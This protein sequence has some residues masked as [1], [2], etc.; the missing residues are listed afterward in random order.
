MKGFTQK[1]SL[2]WHTDKLQTSLW[3]GWLLT[4]FS[5]FWSDNLV[6]FK[7]L[8]IGYLFPFRIFLPVTA[9]LYLIWA[10]REKDFFWKN[11]SLLEKWVYVLIAVMLMYGVLSLPRALNFM[12]TFQKLFNLC[13]D[14]CF[15]FLMLRLCQNKKLLCYTI[16]VCGVA[17]LII[18]GLGIFEIFNGGIFDNKYDG[19]SF[20]FLFNTYFQYPLVGFCCCNGLS[21]SLIFTAC[22]IFLFLSRKGSCSSVYLWLTALGLPLLWF[23]ILASSSRLCMVAFIILM[24]GVTLYLLSIDKKLIKFPIVALLLICGI[25]FAHEYRNIVPPIQQYL[26][27]MNEYREQMAPPEEGQNTP[28]SVSEPSQSPEIPDTPEKPRL[29][30]GNSGTGDLKA[31][32]F[33]A[34]EATGEETLNTGRSG[35]IRLSLLLHAIN[36]FKESY[37]L[38]VGLG[39]TEVLAAQRVSVPRWDELG[40]SVYSIHC[41]IAR[42]IADYG[43]F[44]FVP[45]CVIA[46]LLMK[47]V[48]EMFCD[49]VKNRD[50]RLLGRT[51][52]F[53]C[54]LMVFPFASTADGDTQDLLAMWIYLAAVV[55]FANIHTARENFTGKAENAQLPTSH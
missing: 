12:H 55:L 3:I 1:L 44:V 6:S 54:V 43:I 32:F 2:Q 28:P 37:G 22:A 18:A 21:A 24:I 46:F 42:I 45:L 16:A 14:M 11:S 26:V 52:L 35:G 5:S 38:G 47:R 36:C 48:W 25:Q 29:D 33:V 53:A 20:F 4:V 10:I 30:F 40:L 34:N 15:F 9:L 19:R 13:I 51:I 31:E 49:S 39:N 8:N 27:E 23:L 17:V 50:N 7:I 41:F